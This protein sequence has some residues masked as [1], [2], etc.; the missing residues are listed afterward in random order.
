MDVTPRKSEVYRVK[1]VGDTHAKRV[2]VGV[3]HLVHCVTVGF[4]AL[5]HHNPFVIWMFTG[6]FAEE[7]LLTR[8]WSF[9]FFGS[10][11]VPR[12]SSDT[13]VFPWLFV[14]L[15]DVLDIMSQV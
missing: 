8:V 7:F 6:R 10:I 13:H 15:T 14:E 11:R 1:V 5:P 3:V 9:L 2:R 4:P 12:R